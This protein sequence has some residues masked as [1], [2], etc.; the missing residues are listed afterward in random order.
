VKP[1]IE[2]VAAHVREKGY[3]FDPEHFWSFYESNGWRVGYRQMRSWRAA[4]RQS[5]CTSSGGVYRSIYRSVYN[6]AR[7]KKKPS[8]HTLYKEKGRSVCV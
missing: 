3:T 2:E 4:C 5:G 1:T 8:P 7:R 6:G